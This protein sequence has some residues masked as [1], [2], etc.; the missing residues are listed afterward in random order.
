MIDEL[1]AQSLE[2]VRRK[3]ETAFTEFSESI[4]EG[5][6]KKGELIF[7]IGKTSKKLLVLKSGVVKHFRYKDDGSE[8]ITW[9][10][11]EGDVVT[12]YKS[13]VRQVPSD[14]GVLALEDC[15]FLILGRD[16]C[17]ELAAKYHAVETFFRELLEGYY[18]A[19]DERLFFLQALTARQKYDYI[20]NNMPQFLQ[21]V[22]QKELAS[23]LG[24]TRETLSRIRK[25]N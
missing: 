19:S 18:I 20:L 3:N 17:Y 12:P 13:F 1:V 5:N 21:L 25:Y 14:E 9:F 22:P 23:F 4:T 7:P 6:S 8:H 10:G 2:S 15:E 24:I 11:F 16:R